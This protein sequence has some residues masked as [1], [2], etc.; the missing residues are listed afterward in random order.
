MKVVLLRH[1]AA[2]PEDYNLADMYRYLTPAGRE[3]AKLQ[4][5]RLLESVGPISGIFTSPLTR[6]VQTAE[7]LS[8]GDIP[9]VAVQALAP[10]GRLQDAADEVTMTGENVMVVGH[11][12][13]IEALTSF[14]SGG[15]NVPGFRTAE[16]ALVEDGVLQWRWPPG[17]EQPG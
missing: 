9:V 11:Q 10:Y 7:L 8:A 1:A 17:S 16:A 13:S 15:Q 14:L 3:A 2:V 5:A 12:P 6:A 4:R